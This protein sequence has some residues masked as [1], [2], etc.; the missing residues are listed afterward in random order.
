M[1]YTIALHYALNPEN[2]VLMLAVTFPV[3]TVF[4]RY[5]PFGIAFSGGTKDLNTVSKS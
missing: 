4:F 3:G 1:I 5:P 2:L